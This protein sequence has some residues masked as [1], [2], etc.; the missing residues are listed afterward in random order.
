MY[1]LQAKA[2]A[3]DNIWNKLNVHYELGTFTAM[4]KKPYISTVK[5]TIEKSNVNFNNVTKEKGNLA[6][7]WQQK[8]V[9][10]CK[11]LD[12]IKKSRQFN[13]E[14]KRVIVEHLAAHENSLKLF[15][16]GSK[17]RDGTGYSVV[18][19]QEV[20]ARKIQSTAST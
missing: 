13:E 15:T 8:A 5:D 14:L 2:N 9:D 1:Y 6:P 19:G 10:R 7:P 4:I 20:K 18:K 11:E 12:V 17:T 3:D 16:D